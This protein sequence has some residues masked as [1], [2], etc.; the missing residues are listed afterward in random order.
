MTAPKGPLYDWFNVSVYYLIFIL[1]SR[2]YPIHLSLFR[3]CFCIHIIVEYCYLLLPH[4]LR[5]TKSG[6]APVIFLHLCIF[7]NAFY[8]FLM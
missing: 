1:H 5:H 8:C 2:H 7:Y 3:A 4:F 6:P